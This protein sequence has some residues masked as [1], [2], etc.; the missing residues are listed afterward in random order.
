MSTPFV[1]AVPSK[2]RLQENAEAFF[3]QANLTLAKPRG[4]REYRGTMPAIDNVEIAYLSASEIAAQLA[5]GTVHLGITGE[6]LI[7][8]NIHDADRRV[9]LIESLGFGSANVVVAVPQA[10]IDVRTMADLDDVATSFRARH[11]HRM[12]VATKYINLTRNFFAAQGVVDYRIVESAGATEGAPA[13]GTAE[14]IV[15]ITTTGATL[16]AN[17]LKVLDDGVML[18]SHA[19]LVASRDADWSGNARE[20]ARIILDH[21]AA[22]ARARKYKEVRTRFAACNADLLSEAHRKFGVVSPF[23]GP[24][25]SGMVTLHCPPNQL[26]ALSSFLR[27]NGADTVSIASLDYVFDRENPLFAKLQT[28]LGK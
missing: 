16:A 11:N 3:A 5:R 28:F 9:M 21:I 27:D 25:S 4:A 13:A 15:D 14:L 26:Y 18:R 8:E 10:W 7:R 6:D 2:G 12:R 22:S 24:T 1:V 17:G 20:T 23:G 19:N